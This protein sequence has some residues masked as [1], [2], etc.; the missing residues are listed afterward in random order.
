M[1]L[2]SEHFKYGGQCLESYLLNV[3]KYI[4][5]SQN[6]SSVLK[7]GLLTTTYKKGDWSNPVNYRGITVTPV[8]L[9]I[10]E[11]ILS[12]MH[13]KILHKTQSNLQ[14][15][16][17]AGS[18]S[19]VAALILS[20]CIYEAKNTKATLFITTLDAQKAFDVVDHKMLLRKL[21]LDDIRGNNWLI[22][23]NLYHEMASS[24]KWEGFLSS[25]FVICEGV[26]QGGAFSS[27]HY[28]RYNNPLL[29]QLEDKYT[30]TLIESIQIP[31]VTV[32]D[33]L[34]LISDARYHQCYM[35]LMTAPT[36]TDT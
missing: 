22:L 34:L 29:L 1:N 2:T 21:Y 10:L 18:S 20:E 6:I 13:N 4:I 8:I 5:S 7:E 12:E 33:D 9:K 28:K 15:G 32:V 31:H 11:H 23:Q 36:K 14:K 26:C 35:M 27:T 30:G 25:P 17:T 19:I 16:F 24:V 3:M